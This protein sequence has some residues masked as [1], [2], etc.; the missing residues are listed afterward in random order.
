L[1]G[2]TLLS[3]GETPA[4]AAP[5]DF[6]FDWTAADE[7]ALAELAPYYQKLIDFYG[8]DVAVAK[9]RIDQDYERGLR[10]ATSDKEWQDEGITAE[11]QE[12]KR[13]FDIALNDLDQQLNQRGVFTSGIRERERE[14]A[15]QAERYQESLLD[16]QAQG[17]E[18]GLQQ[19]TEEA[20]VERRRDL[21][22]LGYVKPTTEPVTGQFAPS[23]EGVVSPGPS[24]T[25]ANFVGA[26]AQKELAL[27]EQKRKDAIERASFE[28]TQAYEKWFE[29][30]KRLNRAT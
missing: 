11:R 29:D 4:S 15:T 17:L 22:E 14:E 28:H 24:Y 19:F 13:R 30:A 9:Q 16:R 23:Q 6:S 8:G 25:T 27:E 18:R 26:P 12:R 5:P 1:S 3:A 2:Q 20:G 7:K 10:V 21:E